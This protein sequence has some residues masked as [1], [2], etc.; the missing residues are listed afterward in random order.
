[1]ILEHPL[2]DQQRA[3][4]DDVAKFC[5]DEV[6]PHADQWDH[7]EKLPREIFTKAGR[8]GL[9]GMVAP[10]EYG[11]RGLSYVVAALAIKEMAKHFAALSMDIAA[12]NALAVGQIT[13]FGTEEQKRACLPKLTSG[14]WLGAWALT[15]PNAGSDTGGIETKATA[16]G[17]HWHVN[18][19]KKFITSGQTAELLVI[20]ATTGKTDKGKN[21]ISA[22]IMMQDQ[23][24][25][26]RRI[27]TYGM[28]ASD[29]AELRFENAKA[30][31]LGARGRG[32]EQ[33]LSVLDRGR[34]GIGALAVGIAEAAFDRANSYANERKQ[35][36]HAIGDFQAVQ[37]MLVDSAMDL[38]AAEV[39][40][41]HAASLQDRGLNTTKESAIAKLFASEAAVRICDRSM[42]IHGGYGYSRDLPI[43]RYLRDA[44]LCEIGEGTSQVQRLVIARHVLK[45]AKPLKLAHRD[46]P[47]SNS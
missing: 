20:M 42:Q 8:I 28:R 40:T 5:Q 43:E 3:F 47:L 36:G 38:E 13:Q 22:F 39:L 11:G 15:E 44:K 7:D 6:A 25:P 33:A 24:T 19:L 4:L 27:H 35:F 9:M 1:M 31:M 37:W 32:R 23:V 10:K 41:M 21:E 12:H 30:E 16:H 18:G 46:R 34:I 29:T 45:E 14:E 2:D 26:V 17:D